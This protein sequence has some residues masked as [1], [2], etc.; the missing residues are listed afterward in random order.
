MRAANGWRTERWT[1]D[2]LH[3]LRLALDRGATQEELRMWFH[4][5]SPY[6]VM[7]KVCAYTKELTAAARKMKGANHD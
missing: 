5:R 3:E 2:E 4:D 7:L 6:D 1:D